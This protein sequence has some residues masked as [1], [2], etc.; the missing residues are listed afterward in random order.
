MTA[1]KLDRTGVI[2]SQILFGPH[3]AKILFQAE[4]LKKW[5]LEKK[6]R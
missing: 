2:Q 3:G 5:Q 1:Y 4:F 6:M